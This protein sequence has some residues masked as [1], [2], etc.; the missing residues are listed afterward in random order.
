MIDSDWRGGTEL[1]ARL[2]STKVTWLECPNLSSYVFFKAKVGQ[3]FQV[4]L[5]K[6]KMMTRCLDVF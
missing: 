5:E 6:F 4:M 2:K 3:E 1:D